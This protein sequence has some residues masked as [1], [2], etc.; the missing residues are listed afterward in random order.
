MET[1]QKTRLT[2]IEERVRRFVAD[3]IRP[4]LYRARIPLE[5]RCRQLHGE[6]VPFREATASGEFSPM[7][8]GDRWGTPWDTAWM[9]MTA[10]LPESWAED[11]VL[12]QGTVL[13]ADIDLG[14][15]DAQPGFQCEG[16]AYDL[17]GEPV[18]GINPRNHQVPVAPD[19][20]DRV[21]FWV[22]AAAN[23]NVS[24]GSVVTF[25]PTLLGL[26]ETAGQEPTYTLRR[27]DL[28]LLDVEVYQL[29]QDVDV[30]TGVASQSRTDGP[31]RWQIAAALES[32][33]NRL[34]PS[35]IAGTAAAGRAELTGVMSRPSD[36]SA[37]TVYATGHAHIDSAWL[38]PFR[39][40]IRKCAR[41][42][43]NALYLMD[44]DPAFVFTCSSAQQLFWIKKYYPGL[45][46]RIRARAREGRFV[47]TGG[48]WVESDT[49]LP[50]G[51]SLARQFILG[52]RFFQQ[53]FGITCAEAWLPDSFGYSG[54]LPQIAARAGITS[55][56]TQKLSWN[57]VNR[58]P[59]HT[60]R[61]EGIDGTSLFTHMPP[62]ETYNSELSA[63]ELVWAQSN[64][65]D[66]LTA[67]M[68][69]APFGWG[70][71]GGG[72]TREML[73]RA[74][75]S[76]DL[77]GLPR[78]VLSSAQDF[79]AAAKQ[80]N[81]DL[82]VWKGEMYLELHRGTY[83]SQAHT[84]QGNRRVESLLREAELWAATASV[85]AG[86]QYPLEMLEEAWRKTL[87][88]Q[89]HDVITGTSIAWVHQDAERTYAQIAQH[90]E[91][92]IDS[93]I[94]SLT[95][96]DDE[97][98]D[99]VLLNSSP[100]PRDGVPA[101]GAGTP[102]RRPEPATAA[103][104]EG[105]FVLEDEQLRLVIDSRGLITELR[106]LAA[107]RLVIGPSR[108][109]NLLQLHRDEPTEWD[110][111]DVDDHYRQSVTDL[112]AADTVGPA[113]AGRRITV[114][115]HFGSSSVRQEISLT[116]DAV[117]IR[118]EVDWHEQER[119]LKLAFPLRVDAV[120][121]QAETQFGYHRR[122]TTENTSWQQAQF[123]ICAHRWLRVGEPGYGVGIANRTTYGHDVTRDHDGD[124]V[125]T[126]V[127]QSLLRGPLFPD[128]ETD[129]GRQ[130]FRTVLV[131]GA[132]LARTV[133]A[134][135][136]LAFPP[137]KAP[138]T[139]GVEPL[140][141]VEEGMALIDTVKLAED[142]S[143]DVVARLYEPLGR[144]CRATVTAHFPL[145]GVVE[146][147]L[148]ERPIGETGRG[149]T[150]AMDLH[151]FQVRTLRFV[152]RHHA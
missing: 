13:E 102:G 114:T 147:D 64:F 10:Q 79:F 14:I 135:F 81:P 57:R 22:E 31:R 78:V 73:S 27:A 137:R 142:G 29:L 33:V 58:M 70:D 120:E 15:I 50:S 146:T 38:W 127:R 8:P 37:H 136:E 56:L 7:H 1:R 150:H 87:L 130:V 129:Q 26:K 45:F 118:T 132:D 126:T 69:L 52:Q 110:A 49:N 90:L 84:K 97:A 9:R 124:Q 107:D 40:T 88:L 63:E 94:R 99:T 117:Q 61:W 121:S 54:G 119:L 138:A 4:H 25:R 144:A 108:P 39:E 93:S 95:G 116:G 134:G 125:L 149:G 17:S 62:M 59:H 140:V 92:S 23:P 20:G 68:S 98:R 18:K 51:E 91:E 100:F 131:P 151:P 113:D 21:D 19:A 42:F 152:R 143:G 145:T 115:R 6:P 86:V 122:P 53:E 112:R 43:S 75:R 83:T 30:I 133:R 28:A 35:D 5:V 96:A 24:G 123:E 82:P 103:E 48:M 74:H 77:E 60:F 72:P 148:L 85:R 106:D 12:R 139:H 141:S 44:L 67:T 34:D 46:K 2:Q 11:G 55:F 47:P 66:H 105:S 109:G 41:T 128:P 104:Q 111:W 65:A 16:L 36:A 71:G 89:F 101:L 76:A 32:M 3:R 80:E